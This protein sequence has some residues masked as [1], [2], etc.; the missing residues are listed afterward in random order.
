MTKY[1]SKIS[2][3]L[4][5]ILS[6]LTYLP[7]VLTLVWQAAGY[8]IIIWAI[9]L[10]IQGVLPAL[11]IYLV[12]TAINSLVALAGNHVYATNLPSAFVN[13][14]LLR[15]FQKLNSP[16]KWNGRQKP[17]PDVGVRDLHPTRQFW[18]FI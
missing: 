13:I 2:T 6:Q 5:S 12:K 10:I 16:S 17:V 7:Q 1:T 3:K 15:D 11:Q 4:R 9:L 18:V 14:A 8:W